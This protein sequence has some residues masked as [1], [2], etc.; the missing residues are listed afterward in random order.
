[1][2]R[3][4]LRQEHVKQER[5]DE[6]RVLRAKKIGLDALI[7]S[8][9]KSAALAIPGVVAVLTADDL[10]FH[11]GVPCASNPTGDAKQPDASKKAP[12]PAKKP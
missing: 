11:A 2:K 3:E 7:K 10:E 5:K 6:R 1:M 9:D 4:E 8:I 12:E